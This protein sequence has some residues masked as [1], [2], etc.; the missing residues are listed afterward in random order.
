MGR[1]RYRIFR[2]SGV[3]GE[4]AGDEITV[5]TRRR[6]DKATPSHRNLLNKLVVGVCI[7]NGCL[8][9]QNSQPLTIA[10]ELADFPYALADGFCK[11]L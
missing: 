2:N 1:A 6:N 10:L 8:T 5:L 4:I 11:K 3:R 7:S 9:F